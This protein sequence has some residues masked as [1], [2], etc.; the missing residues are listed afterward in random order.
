MEVLTPASLRSGMHG[1][2]DVLAVLDGKLVIT[3][4]LAALLST[5]SEAR[6]EILGLL[7]HIKDRRLVS[8]FNTTKGGRRVQSASFDWLSAT[9]PAVYD[10]RGVGNLLGARF[11]DVLMPKPNRLA[12]AVRAAENN[13]KLAAIPADLRNSAIDIM[14]LVKE[15]AAKGA[16]DLTSSESALLADWVDRTAL[17]RSPVA[18][19]HNHN[20]QSSPSAEVGTDLAQTFTRIAKGLKTLGVSDFN[21]YVAMLA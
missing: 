10:Y 4:D 20:L 15:E 6:N 1:G 3:K 5:R 18:R 11:A 19:D 8:D 7:R 9:T 21:P 2:H 12:M 13:P 17:A 16:T 14:N